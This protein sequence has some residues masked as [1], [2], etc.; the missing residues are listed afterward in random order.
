VKVGRTYLYAIVAGEAHLDLVAGEQGPDPTLLAVPH[1]GLTAVVGDYAGPVFETLSKTDL[2]ARLAIHQSVLERLMVDRSLLPVKFG[3]TLSSREDAEWVLARYHNRLAE[4]LSE[5]GD[6]VEID[7][8]ASWDLNG[9]LAD[10]AQEPP[11][12]AL[13]ASVPAAS[14]DEAMAARVRVG[15]EVQRALERRREEYRRKIVGDLMSLARDAEP[16]PLPSEEL[17]VNLAFLVGRSQLQGFEA[18]V[19]RIGEELGDRLAFRY[20]GPL[21]PYSFATVELIYPDPQEIETARRMLSLGESLS[22]SELQSEYRRLAAH[23][24]PD[25][26]P[27]DDEARDRF[28]SLGAARHTLQAYLRGQRTDERAGE[29]TPVDMAPDA[30]AKTILLEIR[31]TDADPTPQGGPA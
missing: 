20:V 27:G 3:T 15:T 8:S 4:A 12:A 25:R 1:S 30:V 18:A 9:M 24:H 19:D 28:D 6:A 29:N 14:G 23:S 7:L 22:E 5:V 17:V 10:I 31:R 11:I 26:N 2:F 21:P 13:A 16:N